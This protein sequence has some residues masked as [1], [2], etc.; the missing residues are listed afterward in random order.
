MLVRTASKLFGYGLSMLLLAVASLVVIPEMI[1]VSGRQGWGSIA[2]GQ[3]IGTIA[4][5]VM[6]YGWQLSGP[7]LIVRGDDRSRRREYVEAL[8]LKSW[9]FLPVAGLAAWVSWLFAPSHPELAAVGA[10]FVASFGLSGSW[11]FVGVRRPYMLLVTETIPRVAGTLFSI[12]LMRAGSGAGVGLLC[13]L[14]GMLLGVAISSAWIL[15]SLPAGDRYREP[16]RATLVRQRHGLGASVASSMYITA[17]LVI[18]RFVAPGIQ[19]D[20]ALVDKL[21]RQIGVALTPFISVLQGWVPL[22]DGGDQHRRNLHAMALGA[23]AAIFLGTGVAVFGHVLVQYIGGG[24]IDVGEGVYLLMGGFITLG[25]FDSCMR[26]AILPVI[27]R[28]DVVSRA[29]GISALIGFPAMALG[30]LVSLEVALLGLM[31]GFIVRIAIELAVVLRT[32]T[33]STPSEEVPVIDL[34]SA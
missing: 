23:A 32:R 1:A 2:L 5:V 10:I 31:A 33:T 3:G 8:V 19:P 13:Q 17:P 11:Y 20:Y 15:H 26:N 18:I 24:A 30:A 28:V 7:T 27:G 29:T 9:L 16:V 6:A 4:A 34:E 21:Q 25:M 12:G 14:A 22:R